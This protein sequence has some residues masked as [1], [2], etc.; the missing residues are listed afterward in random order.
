MLMTKWKVASVV[1]ALGVTGVAG[2]AGT[3]YVSYLLPL[4]AAETEEQKKQA[5]EAY[6]ALPDGGPTLE[7]SKAAYAALSTYVGTTSVRS[8]SIMDGRKLD[9]T[10][11]ANIQFRRPNL[12][13]IEGLLASDGTYKIAYDG[14]ETASEATYYGQKSPAQYTGSPERAVD[15]MTGV[16]A[17]AP[18]L[19]PSALMGLARNPFKDTTNAKL[20]GQED[21]AGASCYKVSIAVPHDKKTFWVDAKSFLLRRYSRERDQIDVKKDAEARG[22][23]LPADFDPPKSH[24][25]TTVH[26]FT[27][28]SAS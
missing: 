13:H 15:A 28:K 22:R 5:A 19:I 10:A 4:R 16:A 20:E 17:Q 24:S 23:K 12:L 3:A 18:T 7:K 11:T 6:A 25:S 1:M 2:I 21:I 14:Q 26:N 9:Q 8:Q 27:I